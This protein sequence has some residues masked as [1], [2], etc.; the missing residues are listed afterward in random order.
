MNVND[1]SVL[2]VDELMLSSA[3]HRANTS[4]TQRTQRAPCH[5][6]PQRCVQNL[7]SFDDRL[8]NRVAQSTGGS[9]DLRK[10]RHAAL[11]SRSCC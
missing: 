11:R 2:E 6:A 3:F 7:H 1:A 4:A 8:L 9:L 10:L 5:P